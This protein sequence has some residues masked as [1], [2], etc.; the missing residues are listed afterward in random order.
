MTAFLGFLAFL[1]Q[2]VPA[3]AADC[4][5]GGFPPDCHYIPQPMCEAGETMVG[6][7]ISGNWPFPNGMTQR[8][9]IDKNLLRP[10]TFRQTFG[11]G[12]PDE[13][14]HLKPSELK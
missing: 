7:A 1:M 8:C 6:V 12:K 5:H 10:R 9:V 11:D 13:I 14:F 4:P 2:A 3:A